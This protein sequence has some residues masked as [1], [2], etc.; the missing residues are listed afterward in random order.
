MFIG[1]DHI[2]TGIRDIGAK[3]NI[4]AAP[5]HVSRDRNRAA[6]PR[7]GNDR[8]FPLIVA[9]IQSLVRYMQQRTQPLGFFHAGSAHQNGTAR[10][11]DLEDLSQHRTFLGGLRR[12]Q[13]VGII[14]PDHG[15]VCRNHL[16][17]HAVN[18]AKL[19]RLCRGSAGHSAPE[20]IEPDQILQRDRAKNRALPLQRDALFRL[21]RSL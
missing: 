15:F 18:I 2:Q 1:A 13:K 10:A 4:G 6:Q 9:G 8:R 12:K 16:D 19:L 5:G 7:P 17:V 14:N 21:Q 11:M 20:R 3:L